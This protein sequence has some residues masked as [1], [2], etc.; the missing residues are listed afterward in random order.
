MKSDECVLFDCVLKDPRHTI[1]RKCHENRCRFVGDNRVALRVRA[2]LDGQYD[3]HY[4][5][6]GSYKTMRQYIAVDADRYVVLVLADIL[7]W[8]P[9]SFGLR[10]LRRPMRMGGVQ[11]RHGGVSQ[12]EP[13]IPWRPVV[14]QFHSGL[15]Q[16]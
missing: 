6:I 9:T 10:L 12:L 5:E 14:D 2:T 11:Q 16:A 3:A 15:E 4:T 8:V 7:K 13:S 1:A